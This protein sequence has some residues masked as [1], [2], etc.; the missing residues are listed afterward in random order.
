MEPDHHPADDQQPDS[1][2]PGVLQQLR[3]EHHYLHRGDPRDHVPPDVE[4]EPPDKGHVRAPAQDQGDPGAIQ[5]REGQGLTGDPEP[6]QEAGRQSAGMSGAAGHPV[7]HLYRALP[8]PASNPALHSREADEPG[9]EAVLGAPSGAPGRAAGQQLPGNGPSEGLV[10][11]GRRRN[12]AGV[13]GGRLHVGHAEDDR[14]AGRRPATTVHHQDDA[15]DDADHVRV[16]H[17][18]FS[19]RACSVLGNLKHRRYRDP[20]VRH[21]L[22]A[23]G[24]R[25]LFPTFRATGRGGGVG[26]P[27]EGGGNR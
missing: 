10:R 26:I 20:G 5:K 3:P 2:L 22:G 15:V 24:I 13:S 6:L 25:A 23:P 14:H 17:P 4:A 12:A 1:S 8:G 11:T 18:V 16:L 19:G 7:P 27:G 9:R 21:G